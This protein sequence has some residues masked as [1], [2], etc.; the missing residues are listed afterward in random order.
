LIAILVFTS[1]FAGL[2]GFATILPFGPNRIQ[3]HSNLIPNA[4]FQPVLGFA[5]ISEK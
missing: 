1:R 3:G 2:K 4:H 5:R